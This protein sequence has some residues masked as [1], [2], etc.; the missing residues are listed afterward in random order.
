MS[1]RRKTPRIHR[2][3]LRISTGTGPAALHSTLARAAGEFERIHGRPVARIR[4]PKLGGWSSR[5]ATFAVRNAIK[6]V[7]DGD[8]DDRMLVLEAPRGARK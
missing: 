7:P 6:T 5:I 3:R 8:L 4:Y 2:A 1:T